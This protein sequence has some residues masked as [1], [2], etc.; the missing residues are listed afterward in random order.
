[1]NPFLEEVDTAKYDA[2]RPYFHPLVVRRVAGVLGNPG[3][4]TSLDVA[5]GTGYSTEALTAISKSV[6]GL[7]E[8]AEMLRQARCRG[9]V[10][11]VRGLAED[12]PFCA[13]SFDLV[14]VG[15][16]LHWF[17]RSAFLSEA[18]RVLRDR[19][20]LLVYDSGF[21]GRMRENAA[22]GDWVRQYRDRFPAP[23]RN[24]EPLPAELLAQIGF[25]QVLSEQF[26]HAE[27]YDLDQ[28]VAYL[29]TQS[30]IRFALHERHETPSTIST[31]LRTTLAPM[32]KAV[33]GT[34]EYQGWLLLFQKAG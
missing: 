20:W 25:N 19:C 3:L 21:C 14:S 15:L 30:N 2:A 27:V 9:V 11:Y 28:L 4:L 29:N 5:C 34:F 6:V 33:T 1:M 24:D 16:G 18:G 10:P 31:W 22:F 8:S 13:G 17:D 12:L 32:F 26:V 7:D 23:P